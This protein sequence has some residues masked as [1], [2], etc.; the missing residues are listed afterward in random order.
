[1]E[2][3]ANVE[4]SAEEMIIAPDSG[5]YV[6]GKLHGFFFAFYAGKGYWLDWRFVSYN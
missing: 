3:K 6:F 2:K 4:V 5:L 1:M